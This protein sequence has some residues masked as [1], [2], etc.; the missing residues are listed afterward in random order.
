MATVQT[1]LDRK[2]HHVHNIAEDATVL[3]AARSMNEARVGALVITRGDR[4][5]GIFTERDILCRIVAAQ[6]D[7]GQT[8][9]KDVMT[10]PVAVCTPET[11][12]EECRA[13]MMEKRL[14]H[15]PVVKEGQL[16]G[17]I[18]IGDLNASVEAA[19]AETIEYLN[20]YMFGGYK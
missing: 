16:L 8:V 7:P 2:G 20:E 12:R 10:T 4:V 19:Q 17:M 9:V 3:E 13:V 6:R 1:I 11:T 14:R 5:V 15:L 18:S